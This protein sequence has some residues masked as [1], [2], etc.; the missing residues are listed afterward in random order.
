MLEAAWYRP[1]W[2][3]VLLLPLS[4]LFRFIAAS[5]RAY[6]RLL[7]PAK[8]AVPVIVVGNISVGGTGKTPLI[9]TLAQRLEQTGLRV[10]IVS[11]GYGATTHPPYPLVVDDQTPANVCGDEPFMLCRRLRCPVVVDPKRRRAVATLVEQQSCDVII[12]D[13]GLQHY[14]MA[15]DIELVVI[16]GKRGFGNGHCLPA[17]PL[18]EPISRLDTVDVVVVNGEDS[19]LPSSVRQRD[20]QA[21]TLEPE[22][23]VAVSGDNGS[24]ENKTQAIE[25]LL[26]EHGAEP[27]H[28]VAGI[29]NPQR[30]FDSLRLLGFDV[31]EHRFADHHAYTV[32]D[33]DFADD[34][35]VLMTEK[36]AVKCETFAQGSMKGRMWYL[37]VQAVCGEAVI[38][39][40]VERLQTLKQLN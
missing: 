12:S 24:K 6:Y 5:R 31:I 7:P 33:L 9:L 22:Q 8:N 34:Y 29:G 13:D 36:D 19:G 26:A 35:P 3:I 21:M 20:L 27:V 25:D 17:G 14:A 11:R 4:W 10:G 32:A 23:F 1:A 37:Q 30:F 39:R 15:R 16:D 2:W 18:R 28:A 40:I 38:E